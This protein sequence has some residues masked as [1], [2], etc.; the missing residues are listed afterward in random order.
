MRVR[1]VIL[2]AAL[3]LAPLGTWAADLVVWWEAGR[4]PREDQAVEEIVTA[5]EQKTGKDV[6]LVFY[7]ELDLEAKTLAVLAAGRPPDFLFGLDISPYYGQWAHEGRLIDL[8]KVIGPFAELFSPDAL[9]RATLLDA[10]TG[11]RALY[12]LPMGRTTWHVHVW[13]SLL[14]RAGFTL[15]D[16]PKEWKAFWSFWCDRVQPAVRKALDRDDVYGVA[17]QMSISSD[18]H[19]HFEQFVAAHSADYVTR[20][21]RLVIDEPQVRDRLIEALD[22][23]TALYRKGCVP[24]DAVDWDGGGNNRAFLDQRVVMTPNGSL[25]IPNAIKAARPEDYAKNLV[26]IEWPTGINGEPLAIVTPSL[27]A[28]VFKDGGHLTT[29]MAFVRFLVG[30]GWLA[31]WLDFTKDRLLPPMPALLEQP[32]WFDPGNPHH[33]ASARQFLTRP[34]LHDYAAASGEWRHRKVEAELVWAKAIHR[35]VTQGISPEQAADEMIARI[36]QILSE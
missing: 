16:I 34:N 3:V 9:E 29:S 18:T 31:H 12:A 11:K 2:A 4:F 28:A 1:A 7:P 33:I 15:A 17:L 5:F 36:K 6:E 21:G 23:Y 25:S 26:T 19:T 22:G 35:I 24:P 27:E 32:F 30:E 13:R 20:E 8:S 10:T 14:E